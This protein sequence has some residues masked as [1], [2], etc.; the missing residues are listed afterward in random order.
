[1][2]RNT[3]DE[4]I[5]YLLT[6]FKF[7]FNHGIN[8]DNEPKFNKRFNRYMN[9]HDMQEIVF[10]LF[11]ELKKA[12]DLKERYILFNQ[13]STI[14]NAK[15]ELCK[16]ISAFVESRIKEYLEFYNLL[17]NWDKE[18]INSF[19]I[20]EDRRINNS[21]IESRNNQF[22]RLL[23]NVNGFRNF[24]RTRNRILYCLNKKDAY[25]I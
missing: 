24:K 25:K 22:E 19:T 8:L 9:Y 4:N 7:I 20:I 12:Y 6:K 10:N 2:R 17:I 1:M 16:Q 5:K 11:P 3:E 21:Y 14:D 15:E 18:I 23:L 13:T